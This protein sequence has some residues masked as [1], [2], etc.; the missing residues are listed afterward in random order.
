MV[1]FSAMLWALKLTLSPLIVN[2]QFLVSNLNRCQQRSVLNGV[3]QTNF[4]QNFLN[5]S[6][7]SPFVLP[8]PSPPSAQFSPKSYSSLRDKKYLIYGSNKSSL[9]LT[10]KVFYVFVYLQG[11]TVKKI[12]GA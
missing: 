12:F 1:S 9:T 11:Y 2:G 4:T 7:V 5:R 3:F 8:L 10:K 6:A